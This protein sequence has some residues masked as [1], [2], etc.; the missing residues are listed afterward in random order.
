MP[1][2]PIVGGGI[3]TQYS[4]TASTLLAATVPSVTLKT[5]TFM[6]SEHISTYN[7]YT[8]SVA[9]KPQ[10]T[11]IA[12]W[13][14]M[15]AEAITAKVD[16]LTAYF[17]G[18]DFSAMSD[19]EIFQHITDKYEE[20][21]GPGYMDARKY[22]IANINGVLGREP[23]ANYLITIHKYLGVETA[24]IVNRER[25][26][27]TVDEDEV[28]AAIKAKYPPPNAMTVR[29]FYDFGV[30]LTMIG[31]DCHIFGLAQIY[32][33]EYCFMPEIET[34]DIENTDYNIALLEKF[35]DTKMDISKLSDYYYAQIGSAGYALQ[36]DMQKQFVEIAESLNKYLDIN[37]S[38][39]VGRGGQFR[40]DISFEDALKKWSGNAFRPGRENDDDDFIEK[41]W[42]MIFDRRSSRNK[43]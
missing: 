43:K 28:V 16:E 42:D 41:A 40:S 6:P 19:V 3:V 35:L 9:A 14:S 20:A 31:M 21:F 30:E 36:P 38:P 4:R 2:N 8:K 7:N 23:G 27:G 10:T 5:D 22:S 1:I 18:C 34:L 12:P 39:S 24:E 13:R 37:V 33:E 26:Y 17:K 25:L 11:P 29:E 32:V 15:G